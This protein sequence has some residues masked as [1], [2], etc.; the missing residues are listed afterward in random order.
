MFTDDPLDLLRTRET[1]AVEPP[2]LDAFWAGTLAESRALAAPPALER[3]AG[4]LTAIDVYDVSFSG[5]RGQRIRAWLRVPAGTTGRLPTVVQYVGYGGGRGSAID[6][7]ELAASGFAHL[8]MDTRGQGSG[9]STGDTPDDAPPSGPQVP[10]V[11]T[12][13]IQSRDDYYYRRLY[14][15]A[16][17]AV[18]A[19]RGIELVDADRVAVRGGSQGGALA[20]AAA[21]LGEG[22][23]GAI[24][25]VP[26]LADIPHAIEITDAYPFREVVD[27]LRTHR[28]LVA[29]TLHTLSY[30]DTSLLA[31]RATIPA[32]FTV[33][34]MDGVTP[35][36]TVFAAYNAWAG[37][38]A[39]TVW[40][41]NGHEGGGLD[42]F[43]REVA[44]LR[45]ALA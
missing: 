3:I 45:A 27:F 4:P 18:D 39:M 5:F 9:W 32:D 2:D 7:L 1:T 36:S 25:R 15:D 23:R 20:I 10:G 13:G 14:T 22:V 12:K 28:T 37:T 33:G 35:P 38:K 43:E 21:A 11:M 34:L 17:L 6:E 44:F 42:D 16:V 31:R 41:Y 26:F 24:V 29:P 19:A 8:H 30:V 40:P